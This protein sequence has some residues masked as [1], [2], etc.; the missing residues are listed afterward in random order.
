[1]T[2]H[3]VV[4]GDI[5]AT[6]SGGN[7]YDRRIVNGLS[8]TALGAIEHAVPGTWPHPGDA[9]LDGLDRTLATLPDEST[10][11]IDGLVGSAAA[12]VLARHQRLRLIFLMHMPLS[13]PAEEQALRTC[14][15]VVTTSQWTRRLLISLYAYRGDRIHVAEPGADAMPLE[16]GT[17][18]GSRLVCVAAV[19][20]AKG[21]DVLVEA[22]ADLTDLEWTLE[23]VGPLDRDPAYV[24]AVRKLIRD[25]G[26]TDRIGFSGVR[27][28]WNGDLACLASRGE[29]YGM[30]ITEALARG[31]PVVAT[32]VGGVPEALGRPRGGVLVPS[33]DPAAF[34]RAVRSWL[35]NP[36]VRA[37]LRAAAST[38][39]ATLT[40][41]DVT[42][43]KFAAAL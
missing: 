13:T 34:A 38:R 3:F 28:Q 19:T 26:L 23:C 40:G 4:P 9:D 24:D 7:I 10:V 35:T 21:H 41:W 17:A 37:D 29:T 5:D 36:Q 15:A 43:R 16:P 39:R 27:T 30:V 22:L 20:P 18:A 14:R 11:V 6:P 12:P 33:E 25:A 1:V 32:D 2:V 42:V 8:S 31:V